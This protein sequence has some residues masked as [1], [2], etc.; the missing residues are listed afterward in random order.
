MHTLDRPDEPGSHAHMLLGIKKRKNRIILVLLEDET[1]PVDWATYYVDVFIVRI[2]KFKRRGEPAALSSANDS[3]ELTDEE[4]IALK[5]RSTFGP[6]RFAFL[7]HQCMENAP[8]RSVRGAVAFAVSG[9]DDASKYCPEV[10]RLVSEPI[11][12]VD[13]NA[14]QATPASGSSVAGTEVPDEWVA[15]DD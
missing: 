9:D 2:H 5:I 7:M 4:R 1:L 12:P 6:R 11:P 8:L 14:G 3:R 15:T 10:V 13:E